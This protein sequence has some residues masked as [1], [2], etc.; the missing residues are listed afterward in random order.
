MLFANN[1]NQYIENRIK[2]AEVTYTNLIYLGLSE[3][4]EYLHL[5]RL[6]LHRRCSEWD[7]I[8]KLGFLN[9]AWEAKLTGVK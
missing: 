7:D 1:R 2:M 8:A 6:L 5:I 9:L 3:S 4:M